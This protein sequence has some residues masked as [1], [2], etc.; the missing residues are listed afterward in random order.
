MLVYFDYKLGQFE[1]FKILLSRSISG[2]FHQGL[3]FY[4]LD[5][6]PDGVRVILVE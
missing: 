6:E 5:A 1:Y 4:Q 3:L 2:C